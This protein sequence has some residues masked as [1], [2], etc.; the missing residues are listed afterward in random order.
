MRIGILAQYVLPLLILLPP[1][2][3]TGQL[4]DDPESDL[5][6]TSPAAFPETL[7]IPETPD[8]VG[9]ESSKMVFLRGTRLV[10]TVIATYRDGISYLNGVRWRPEPPL[11]STST[12]A[13][14]VT[15]LTTDE[16][17]HYRSI[18]FV[19]A[20]LQQGASLLEAVN[21]YERRKRTMIDQVWTTFRANQA[22]GLDQASAAARQAIDPALVEIDPNSE[23]AP[24]VSELAV[25]LFFHGD[26][27][28]GV[29]TSNRASIRPE[30]SGLTI[31]DAGYDL[32][33]LGDALASPQPVVLIYGA[34]G[35]SFFF[36]ESAREALTEINQVL[37]TRRLPDT[38]ASGS[39]PRVPVQRLEEIV[40]V[41][42]SGGR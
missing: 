30:S 34:T 23:H 2:T 15:A 27:W 13:D 12:M 29:T 6:R 3:A 4:S 8:A 5:P 19:Q 35:R 10:G 9:D 31:E 11:E 7:F 26:G 39:T 37:R 24:K 16:E 41:L 32:R 36:G 22:L 21:T 20:E 40:D 42:S 18:P 38:A 17:Q 25:K 33:R 14:S 28:D 1:S